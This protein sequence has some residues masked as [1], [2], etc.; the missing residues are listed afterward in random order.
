MSDYRGIVGMGA[1]VVLQ[2]C[3]ERFDLSL[4][5]S[6]AGAR[7]PGNDGRI[8][9]MFQLYQPAALLLEVTI[10]GS[11]RTAAPYHV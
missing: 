3:E 9:P 4:D 6:T 2:L 7:L 1:G 5:V 8:E 10:G 11:V